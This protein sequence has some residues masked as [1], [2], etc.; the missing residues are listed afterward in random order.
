MRARCGLSRSSDYGQNAALDDTY[1][2]D[3]D[4]DYDNDYGAP[5]PAG[6]SSSGNPGSSSFNLGPRGNPPL[7]PPPSSSGMLILEGREEL[8]SGPLGC[9][10]DF[11]D[12]R[13]LLTTESYVV[14]GSGQSNSSAPSQ[15][16]HG[17]STEGLGTTL[18]P[19]P[20]R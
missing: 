17:S 14:V 6:S 4:Y 16:L 3:Y 9:T 1:S 11:T 19:L 2:D 15:T 10:I 8:L 5:P 12:S 7:S 13:S 18:F 20:G